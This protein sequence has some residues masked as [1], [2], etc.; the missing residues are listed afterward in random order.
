MKAAPRELPVGTSQL[1]LPM[2]L[3]PTCQP[4]YCM[5]LTSTVQVKFLP[6]GLLLWGATAETWVTNIRVGNRYE[7][8]A[9]FTSRIPGRY[10]AASKTM[11]QLIELAELGELEGAVEPRQILTMSEAAP[12]THVG[13]DVEGPLDAACFW[14][15]SQ[16]GPML[17]LRARIT[18]ETVQGPL[19]PEE[20]RETRFVGVIIESRLGGD[21][22]VFEASGPTPESVSTLLAAY[23]S[24]RRF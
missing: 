15:I 21:E 8:C 14:G 19:R 11:R 20:R 22:T 13:F 6:L 12:G 2:E 9:D 24:S 1:L 23:A 4:G 17:P 18:E 10:F 5:T 16:T 7:G 3:G